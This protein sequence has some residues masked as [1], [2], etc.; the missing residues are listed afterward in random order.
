MWMR[1]ECLSE[2]ARLSICLLFAQRKS[3]RIAIRGLWSVSSRSDAPADLRRFFTPLRFGFQL[4]QVLA[5]FDHVLG[6]LI[7]AALRLVRQ[8]VHQVEHD[9]FADRAKGAGAGV[10]L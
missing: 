6:D 5:A 1:G 9:L 3:P 7:F 10:A 2:G 4:E 8:L